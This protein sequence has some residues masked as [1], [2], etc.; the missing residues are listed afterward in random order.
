LGSAI[1]LWSAWYLYA[2]I[3][4]P[5]VVSVLRDADFEWLIAGGG[6][7]LA[8]FAIRA[9]RL[10]VLA[11][12]L[13]ASVR[14]TSVYVITAVILPFSD[15]T[16]GKLGEG[17]KIEMLKRMGMLGRAE[18]AGAFLIERLSDLLILAA[19]GAVSVLDANRAMPM[20]PYVAQILAVTMVLCVAAFWLLFKSSFL[21][22]F[23]LPMARLQAAAS[24]GRALLATLLLTVCSWS[25]VGV[26]WKVTLR[27]IDIELTFVQTL[28]LMSVVAIVQ[29]ASFVPGGLGIAEVAISQILESYNIPVSQAVAGAVIL[30][31]FGILVLALGGLHWLPW[32]WLYARRTL[33]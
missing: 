29:L 18:A 25:A 32:S 17:L 8:Y 20:P 24:D 26:G 3:D 5:P 12:R 28:W 21:E 22:R 23:K 31:C 27:S 9:L 13:N 10:Y 1:F 14:Y 33:S 15:M 7:G 6:A 4:W 16:P 11:R 30:R 19:M 2:K